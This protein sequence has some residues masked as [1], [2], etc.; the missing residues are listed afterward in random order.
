MFLSKLDS[1]QLTL[2]SA[3]KRLVAD[4]YAFK[5]VLY[6]KLKIQPI[7]LKTIPS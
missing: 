6:T 2:K 5:L 7:F 3:E 4:L 1:S